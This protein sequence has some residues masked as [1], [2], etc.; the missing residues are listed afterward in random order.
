MSTRKRRT[1][2][3]TRSG[4]INA[5][6]QTIESRAASFAAG[7]TSSGRTTLVAVRDS[8]GISDWAVMADRSGI[9][10]AA[11]NLAHCVAARLEPTPTGPDLSGAP[12]VVQLRARRGS[13]AM[14]ATQ[15]GADLAEVSRTLGDVMTEGTWVAAV[16]R[17]P[18]FW[19]RRWW[20]S[21]LAYRMGTRRPTHH[22]TVREAVITTIYAGGQNIA[23]ARD[24][25]DVTTSALPGFDVRTRSVA[26]RR[27]IPAALFFAVA[28]IAGGAWFF[29]A[30][31][32]AGIAAAGLS[33]LAG[34]LNAHS[35]LAGA[36]ALVLAA[37]GVGT[38]AGV[39]P[40][41]ANRIRHGLATAALP[42]ARYRTWPPRKPKTFN[43]ETVRAEEGEDAGGYP[44]RREAFMLGP[45][46]PASLVA[47][48][49]GVLS[50][51]VTTRSRG[52]PVAMTRPIGAMVGTAS[53][54]DPVHLS[55]ADGSRG[56]AVVG[57][58][59]SGKSV[60]IQNVMA[61]AML[62]RTNPGH[63]EDLPG[64]HNAIVSFETK[65][66][67]ANAT[68][69]WA[70]AI[71]D[72]FAFVQVANPD[73]WAIDLFDVPGTVADRAVHFTNAMQYAFADGSI[74]DESFR[75]LTMVLTGALAVND[76]MA[77][78]VEGVRTG[79]SPIY[80]A[81]V[82]I[83]R[84]GDAAATGLAAQVHQASLSEAHVGRSGTDAMLAW[85]ALALMYGPTVTPSQRAA[86][87][88]APGNKIDQLLALDH[89]FAPSR[90]KFSW[91]R[92]LSEHRAVVI[93]TGTDESGH[94][95]ESNMEQLMS[96]LLMFSLRYNIERTCTGWES[97]NRWVS[98]YAD[99]LKELAGSSPDIIAW[100]RN[101]G[102]AYGVRPHFA[103]QYPDQL[104][105][106]VRDALLS[107]AT[108]VAFTQTT[109]AIARQIVE[110]F[111]GDG[112][113]WSATDVLGLPAHH[114]IVRASVG[115]Q[116]Q[117]VFPMA[118]AYFM[119][120]TGRVDMTSFT[121][122]QSYPMPAGGAQ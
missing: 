63:R 82:L 101:K 87:Q 30:A 57:A 60:L 64:A 29:Q 67:G 8:G 12:H 77:S 104:D 75:T 117:P 1:W 50:G 53:N 112:T 110:D 11:L 55:C 120:D 92:L 31:F 85:E 98:I 89:Y 62:G 22:S 54:S 36:S 7:A 103:T 73:S 56:L 47:P 25:L 41:R 69:A 65:L 102:R 20:S 44:L 34:P 23:Q 99:E 45:H 15:A 115:F 16:L 119:T 51:A 21:W 118:S 4:Q 113:E 14:R 96:S 80:Y 5:N 105:V 90:P 48:H 95:L 81:S 108:L 100:L 116:R 46:I 3:L 38:I 97:Q 106:A 42:A 109:P 10:S 19:E 78:E 61:H 83:G 122:A 27:S 121:V 76:G 72:R 32:T 26:V 2:R 28:V 91:R 6:P 39:V 94:I 68:L 114:A 40:V 66:D 59:G 33:E 88:R 93:L 24:L 86:L 74:R 37:M 35:H 58:P 84:L 49:A 9:D 13:A 17:K 107:F 79:G 43:T 111:A 52:V 70:E 18:A 71:G